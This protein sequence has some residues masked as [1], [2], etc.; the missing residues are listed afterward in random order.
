MLTDFGLS[1]M[2]Q[3]SQAIMETTAR[4]SMCGS[5]RWM[6]IELIDIESDQPSR[7]TNE[8]S[9]D[10]G[11]SEAEDDLGGENGRPT[12]NYAQT[13]EST[14]TNAQNGATTINHAQNG[15]TTINQ[16]QNVATAS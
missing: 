8:D 5:V 13:R 2:I 16:A 4:H 6:A 1:R 7:A 12:L 14:T 15:E 11:F 3:Y 9:S 10:E